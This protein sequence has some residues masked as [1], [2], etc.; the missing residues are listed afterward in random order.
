MALLIIGWMAWWITSIAGLGLNKIGVPGWASRFLP[1]LLV[2]VVIS[3]SAPAALAQAEG[4]YREDEAARSGGSCLEPA[5][6]WMRD[7][8]NEPSVVLAPDAVNTCIPAY[9]AQANV[10][11]FRGGLLTMRLPLLEER[12]SG[13]IEIPQS[14]VD[15]SRFFN[16]QLT[17]QQGIQTL[18]DYEVDY[19][20][21][22][23]EHPINGSLERLSGITAK[24]VPGEKYKLYA[25]DRDELGG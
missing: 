17:V 23:A 6:R 21:V 10:V 18:R 4:V 2:V 12:I 14:F 1:L 15:V 5:L 22:P 8:V 16:G 7:N 25:V 19:I 20:L 13:R 3:A 11:S 9:S 24:N